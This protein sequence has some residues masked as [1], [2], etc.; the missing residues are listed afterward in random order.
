MAKKYTY[1]TSKYKF[2]E[3]LLNTFK[4]SNL[5]TLHEHLEVP[6]LPKDVDGLGNDSHSKFHELFYSKLRED[7]SEFACVYTQFVKNE[8]APKFKLENNLIYQKLPSFRIQYPHSKAVTTWHFDN[9]GN[10]AHPLGE[11]NILIPLSDEMTGTNTV[12]AESL[13]GFGDFSP[14]NCKYGEYFLWNGN[15]CRH[16]N[17][18]NSS[19]LTRVSMDFRVLPELWYDENYSLTTATTSQKFV[20]GEYYSRVEVD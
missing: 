20:I 15:R 6:N 1:D 2:K 9:D 16:G 14:M 18:P 5:E 3:I 7:N 17:K 11:L 12:W 19:G 4:V 8:I 10:H 13:P